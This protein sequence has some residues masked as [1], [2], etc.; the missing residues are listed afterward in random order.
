M[1]LEDDGDFTGLY[2]GEVSLATSIPI[3]KNVSLDPRIAYSTA[4]GSDGEDAIT[5]ISEPYD[6]KKD[7][8]YGSIAITAAF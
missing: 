6:G 4:L 3:F 2:Y 7:I 5:A 8:F 1:G